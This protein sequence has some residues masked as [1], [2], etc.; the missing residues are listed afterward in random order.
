MIQ[1][2]R[3]SYCTRCAKEN[4][5]TKGD[6]YGL[7][8]R[9]HQQLMVIKVV[10]RSIPL[11]NKGYTPH[12]FSAVKKGD[13][14]EVTSR[15]LLQNCGH[16]Y[17]HTKDGHYDVYEFK[18]TEKVTLMTIKEWNSVVLYTDSQYWL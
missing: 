2:S 17:E 18:G 14:L 13:K 1:I 16:F 6:M 4:R 15:C 7:I 9:G 10:E 12:L 11:L 3:V 5:P 8:G